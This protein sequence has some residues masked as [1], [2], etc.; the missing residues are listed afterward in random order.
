MTANDTT[1]ARGQESTV[2]PTDYEGMARDALVQL[3][4]ARRERFEG[5][6]GGFEQSVRDGEPITESDVEELRI[7]IER[8][9]ATIEYVLA[10]NVPGVEPWG[11]DGSKATAEQLTDM[12]GT[13]RQNRQ[14]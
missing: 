14:E 13:D 1:P 10:D 6:L 12:L 11:R 7:E 3:L 4:Q 5:R 9:Q 2:G 8:V